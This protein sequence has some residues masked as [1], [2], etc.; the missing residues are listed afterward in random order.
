MQSI[1]E[2][3]AAERSYLDDRRS[4]VGIDPDSPLTGIA[5]SGGGIRSATFALGVLQTL[6]EEDELRNADYLSTVSGGG[7]IGSC[8][9][10]LL[11]VTSAEDPKQT[12]KTP[13]GL[14]PGSFPMTSLA[15]DEDAS[16]EGLSGRHQ[17]HHLRRGGRYLSEQLR[18]TSRAFQR[19]I[20][21]FTGGIILHV[22]MYVIGYVALVSGVHLL[23][24]VVT[25]SDTLNESLI[26]LGFQQSGVIDAYSDVQEMLWQMWLQMTSTFE[27]YGPWHHGATLFQ[28]FLNDGAYLTSLWFGL[29]LGMSAVVGAWFVVQE[30]FHH[31]MQRWF[32]S[33][34]AGQSAR[35][36]AE[37][38]IVKSITITYFVAGGILML[39]P[40]WYPEWAYYSS[41]GHA[42][43][44]VPIPMAVMFTITTLVFGA[45]VE[46]RLR[47]LDGRHRVVRSYLGAVRGMGLTF[48]IVSALV[49]VMLVLLHTLSAISFVT[50]ATALVSMAVG[51]SVASSKEGSSKIVGAILR[52]LQRHPSLIYGMAAMAV[53][54]LPFASLTR[55]LMGSLY[56]T[57]SWDD[58]LIIAIISGGV[59]LLLT[60]VFDANRLSPFRFYRDRIA[61]AF[62]R[63]QRIPKQE[64]FAQTI[65]SDEDL[66]L[67]Q[68]G[69]RTTDDGRPTPNAILAPYHIITAAL[70]LERAKGLLRADSKSIHFLFS[71]RY[72]GSDETGYI[73]TPNDVTVGDAVAVSGAAASS[74][75]GRYSS[76][77]QRFFS[78]LFNV[79][80]GQ[81]ILNPKYHTAEKGLWGSNE[82][83]LPYLMREVLGSA[84]AS[85]R[86][87]HVS[88]GGHT[89]DN[90]GLLP[91]LQR[92]CEV[93]VVI[94]GEQ[95]KEYTFGSFN[96]AIRLALVELDH[97]IDIDL[98]P[99]EKK[100]RSVVRGVVH[101]RGGGHGTIYYAKSSVTR[102]DLGVNLPEHVENYDR[103]EPDF[104][105][106]STG[107]QFFDPEQFEAYRALGE[108]V[109]IQL[110]S[111]LRRAH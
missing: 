70:N 69:R 27:V 101:Y 4:T 105:H 94:D 71:P 36:M 95:D 7:Y 103:K 84:N 57:S 29:A 97:R 12:S 14:G 59:L 54:I 74:L 32:G 50:L 45:M 107:D 5:I 98:G 28:P 83:W 13:A 82:I 3:I 30:R 86:R 51:G 99:I 72:V 20:G 21:T 67:N 81:W 110:V 55:W 61:E 37:L 85:T 60:V 65:R 80:L 89:G 106:Q 66:K 68:L 100:E 9:T 96:H 111:E 77:G 15:A 10:S 34:R 53:I 47:D 46:S 1:D 18:V 92:K 40:R 44:Y 11:T 52:W 16:Y 64:G 6:A 22:V 31:L 102:P 2:V 26:Y 75:A 73:P 87:I 76:F 41:N 8:L 109:G 17:M 24:M 19:L 56:F 39:L 43:L 78:V 108:Y 58:I 25:G 91:L 48:L 49:P 38:V 90:L 42:E 79:R 93:I 33:N 23:S 88:D 35:S 104:P 62:L 63:T